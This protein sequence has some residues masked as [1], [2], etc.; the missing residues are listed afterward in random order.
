[1]PQ[2]VQHGAFRYDSSITIPDDVGHHF[3]DER[4]VVGEY[5]SI[6]EGGRCIGIAL[7]QRSASDALF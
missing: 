6:N 3:A 7:H 2:P 1:M 4:F 5:V